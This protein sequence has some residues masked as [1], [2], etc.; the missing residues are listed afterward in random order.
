LE[1]QGWE[2]LDGDA[3]AKSLYVPG[4]G[5]L[6]AVAKEFGPNV[7]KKDG[8]LDPIR[9]GE[10]V[11]PSLARRRAL[12]RIVYPAFAR[13]LRARIAQARRARRKLVADV[14]VY[15][16]LGAPALGMPVVLLLAPLGVRVE[17]LKA[18]GLPAGRALARA[19]ALS[20]GPKQRAA[21][22]L[23]LDGR[24]SPPALLGR[25]ELALAGWMDRSKEP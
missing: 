23:V 5:L 21:A 14:A 19:R 3:L 25:L 7:L 6:R 20:F 13:A 1:Q 24:E 11:F 16:D 8:R 10:I 18:A 4:S 15:Y 9:L 2:R 22:D 12:N 17:R